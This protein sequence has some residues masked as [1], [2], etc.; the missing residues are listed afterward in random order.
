MID[1]TT[2]PRSVYGVMSPKPTVVMVVIAQYTPTGMLWST[3]PG[4]ANL[5]MRNQAPSLQF[6]FGT[7]EL[8]RDLFARMMAG[9]RVSIAVGLTV[10]P[11]AGY[12]RRDHRR[13]CVVVPRPGLP[14][15]LS[16]LGPA[17][18]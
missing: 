4:Y 6:P 14:T 3:D 16:D 11:R 10:M 13:E 15:R 9:G 5:R 7:D 17:A 2:R 12:R 1:A 18:L 8:G